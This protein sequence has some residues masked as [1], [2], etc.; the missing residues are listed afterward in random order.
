M[1][2]PSL[3]AALTVEQAYLIG[4]VEEEKEVTDSTTAALARGERIAAGTEGRM[5]LAVDA[6]ARA[7]VV[8]VEEVRSAEQLELWDSMA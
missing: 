8:L 6:L 5:C 7:Q 2:T 1:C 3:A 4:P